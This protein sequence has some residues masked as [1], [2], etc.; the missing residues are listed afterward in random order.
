MPFGL[1]FFSGFDGG[2][3]VGAFRQGLNLLDELLAPS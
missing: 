3:Q 1:R 2:A